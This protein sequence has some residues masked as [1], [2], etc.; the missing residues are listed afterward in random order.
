MKRLTAFLAALAFLLAP[1]IGY[2][3]EAQPDMG[4]ASAALLIN[5]ETGLEVLGK[6]IETPVEAAGLRRLP[7]LLTVCLAFDAEKLSEET[8]ITVS[9]AAADEKGM[10]A[11]L[12]PNEV[13]P[14]G[15]LLKAAVMLTAGD[16]IRALLEGFSG[17]DPLAAVNGVLSR[18]GA[19]PLEG[20]ALGAGRDFTVGEI[21]KVCTEL[22]K[23]P[24]WLKYSS[25]Y[26]DTLTHG[27]GSVT[28]LTNPNKL[29]RVYS[30]CYGL[31]TGS[32]GSSQYGGAFIAKRGQTTFLAVVTG[33]STSE[34]R[35]ELARGML[36]RG[37]ASYRAAELT[38][39]EY[40]AGTVAVKSGVKRELEVEPEGGAWVLLPAGDGRIS[41]EAELPEAVEAPIEKG[42]PIGLLTIKNAAGETLRELKLLAA[43]SIEKAGFADLFRRLAS[44]WLRM[45]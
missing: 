32:V 34:K 37:F 41:G 24:A 15:A 45:G 42:D 28:E 31:A 18:L 12:S 23:S 38:G 39:E 4:E 6:N 9:R 20:D 22:A 26:T 8:P 19:A 10:T 33:L 27:N 7:A 40:E 13:L 36:D 14:A 25:I 29:V 44:L 1:S 17:G 30:G 35:F 16:A 3:A 11:F 21:A 43:E 2:C 5:I